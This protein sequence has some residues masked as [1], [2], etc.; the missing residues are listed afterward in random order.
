MIVKL[1]KLDFPKKLFLN[2][3]NEET[4]NLKMTQ[5]NWRTQQLKI[6]CAQIGRSYYFEAYYGP[7]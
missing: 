6:T 7:V 1:S 3:E 2:V 5:R 4:R